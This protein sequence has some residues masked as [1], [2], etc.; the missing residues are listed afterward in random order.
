VNPSG[1]IAHLKVMTKPVVSRIS[2]LLLGVTL[3]LTLYCGQVFS[4]SS[5][6][7]APLAQGSEKSPS[8]KR[9]T[10]GPADGRIAFVTASLLEQGHYSKQRFDRAVSIKFF[11]RYLEALD[12]QHL[13]FLQSDLAEFDHYRTNLHELT[14]NGKGTSDTRAGC[15]I[16]NRFLER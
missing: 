3:G 1:S 16:F 4:L 8:A 13:R 7:K 5:N 2:L 15:E 12:P 9:L 14:L 6:E 11:D 10:P